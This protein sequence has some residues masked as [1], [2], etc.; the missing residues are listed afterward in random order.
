MKGGT[1]LPATDHPTNALPD[2]VA[3][4]LPEATSAEVRHH[5]DSCTACSVELASWRAIAAAA[6]ARASSPSLDLA[7]RIAGRIAAEQRTV[8][9][10]FRARAR[11][12]AA[13][14]RGQ[15]PIVRREIWSASALILVI[16]AA[17]SLVPAR[18]SAPG[19]ALALLAPLAAALGIALIYGHENDPAL[20]LALAT[21]TSPRLVV[22]A[23]LTLVL[24]WDLALALG[25]SVAV[26]LSTGRPDGLA[27]LVGLWLGPMLLLGCLSLSLSVLIGTT[28]ALGVAGFIWLMRAAELADL[29]NPQR[30][31]SP[32]AGL[33]QILGI[34]WQTSPLTLAL[35][36]VTVLVALAL[37]PARSGLDPVAAE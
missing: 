23:R 31:G 34:L 2:L 29:A 4:R 3:G 24:G 14:V 33:S 18:G 36:A 22:L 32:G 8:R 10:G 11:W 13:F 6:R 30:F 21:P 25:A 9:P 19:S 26:V 1:G 17:I 7:D 20:E 37:A 27:G 35:A 16:G 15:V 5:L 12:L 28:P